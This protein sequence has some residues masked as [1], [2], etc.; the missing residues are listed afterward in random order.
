[1]RPICEEGTDYGD[2]GRNVTQ[3]P[4]ADKRR[5]RRPVRPP[6]AAARPDDRAAADRGT[7]TA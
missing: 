5:S 2:Y 6:P 7:I 3:P 1:M 4:D